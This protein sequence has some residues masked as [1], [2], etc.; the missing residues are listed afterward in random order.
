ME[1]DSHVWAYEYCDIKC[2]LIAAKYNQEFHNYRMLYKILVDKLVEQYDIV[3]CVPTSKKHI[4]QRGFDHSAYLA[5]I[6]SKRIRVPYRELLEQAYD[7]VQTNNNVTKRNENP[8]YICNVNL[9]NNRILLVDDI[10][11]TCS[12]LNHCSYIL[13][14][15]GASRV[16]C[17]TLAY[18]RK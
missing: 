7:F 4:K 6:I 9:K 5:K 8:M 16:S 2:Q 10:A 18:Q 13:K 1:F 12:S 3:T 17:A 14:R 15:R 11:T